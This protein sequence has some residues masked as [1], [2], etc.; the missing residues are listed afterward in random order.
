MPLAGKRTTVSSD[1]AATE[2]LAGS[3]TRTV[4]RPT[5]AGY[6]EVVVVL[7][8][9]GVDVPT[10]DVVTDDGEPV[11]RVTSHTDKVVSISS[12]TNTCRRRRTLTRRWCRAG[13]IGESVAVGIVRSG[14]AE[15]PD[16]CIASTLGLGISSITTSRRSSLSTAPAE[17][18]GC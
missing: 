9:L 15:R 12:T 17:T 16:P 4:V 11:P 13:D 10:L 14:F 2:P 8:V 18:M 6:G 3:V 1:R 7:V 5:V